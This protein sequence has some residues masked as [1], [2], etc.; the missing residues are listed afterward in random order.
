MN[1]IKTDI[2]GALIIEPRIFGDSRGY[3]FESFNSREFR[4][5]TGLDVTFV[6][7]NESSS[8]YGVVRGLHFQNPPFSQSKLVRVVSGRVLDVA[9]DLRAGS[10]TYGKYAAV[11]L[12]GEN[13]LQFFVPEGFAHG[14]AVLSAGA[15]FQYK[16]SEFYH[17]EAEGAIAWNDP[18]IAI[19]WRLP[20]EDV[21]LSAKDAGHPLLKNFTTPFM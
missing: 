7:D 12:T 20:A 19:D 14:F 10:P 6:Q 13:H 2:E 18:D 16:C 15:L 8:H 11:E 5:K 4:E 17:P 9:V 3:F 1:I 21:E